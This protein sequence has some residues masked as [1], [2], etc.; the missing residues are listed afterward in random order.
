MSH[1]P[2]KS[3]FI[4]CTIKAQSLFSSERTENVH[5]NCPKADEK[6]HL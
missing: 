3:Y 2:E 4:R 1:I 5:K 6:R